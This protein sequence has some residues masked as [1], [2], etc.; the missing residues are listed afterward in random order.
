M[1]PARRVVPVQRHHRLEGAER[2]LALLRFQG[3]QEVARH[4]VGLQRQRLLAALPRGL[5]IAAGKLG[6]TPPQ[7]LLYF[8]GRRRVSGVG[9]R[10]LAPGKEFASY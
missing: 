10:W 9:Y 6:K 2:G 1:R 3:D 7:Q 8:P 5:G 4:Q